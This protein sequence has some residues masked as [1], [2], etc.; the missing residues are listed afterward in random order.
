MAVYPDKKKM[1]KDTYICH[2]A[3]FH[4][5]KNHLSEVAKAEA[6]QD[7]GRMPDTVALIPNSMDYAIFKQIDNSVTVHGPASLQ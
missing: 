3:I 7:A 4:A 2:G 1:V 6:Q 5:L